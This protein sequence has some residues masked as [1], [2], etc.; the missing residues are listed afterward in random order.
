MPLAAGIITRLK[1]EIEGVNR[2]LNL[3]KGVAS[4]FISYSRILGLTHKLKVGK[5]P[6][7]INPA[8]TG[9]TGITGTHT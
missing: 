5:T 9:E 1:A 7:G 6:G 8:P 2:N 3:R 4:P